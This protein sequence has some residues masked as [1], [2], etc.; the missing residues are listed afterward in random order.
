[1]KTS[2]GSRTDPKPE[3][4][5]FGR[6]S[7]VARFRRDHAPA[8]ALLTENRRAAAPVDIPDSIAATTRRRKSTSKGLPIS[9]SVAKN[10]EDRI[11]VRP[12]RESSTTQVRM[13][14]L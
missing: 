3:P 13:K 5:G 6:T 2:C 9:S 4:C 8:A 11:R 10:R 1:M 14:T 12:K 7:P